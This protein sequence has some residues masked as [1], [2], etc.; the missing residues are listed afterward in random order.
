LD[1][2]HASLDE[3]SVYY[4]GLRIKVDGLWKY[5]FITWVGENVGGLTRARVSMHQTAVNNFFQGA[6][7]AFFATDISDLS[8]ETVAGEVR[9][10]TNA[11]AVEL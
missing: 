3:N 6:I 11:V 8:P 5:I 7:A 10:V 9:K 1:G 2:L 4:A